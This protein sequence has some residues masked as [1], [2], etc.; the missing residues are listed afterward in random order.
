[1]QKKKIRQN[2][3][4]LLFQGGTFL[5][6][7]VGVILFADLTG[8]LLTGPANE[9]GIACLQ[10]VLLAQLRRSELC[11]DRSCSMQHLHIA[12]RQ[13][14]M[15]SAEQ[16]TEPGTAILLLQ[17]ISRGSSKAGRYGNPPCPYPFNRSMILLTKSVRDRGNPPVKSGRQIANRNL[18]CSAFPRPL[19]PFTAK[20]SLQLF[21][22]LF[23]HP[24]NRSYRCC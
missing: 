15:N 20:K 13:K 23:T 14:S 10:Q 8:N 9:A 11:K 18:T 16:Q 12:H 3:R 19:H 5:I 24:L 1:M 2:V 17:K 7:A 21:C 4:L 6:A 22:P